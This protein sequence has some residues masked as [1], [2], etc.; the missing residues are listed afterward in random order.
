M[1][2]YRISS[3][4]VAVTT[5]AG[6]DVYDRG[7]HVAD[8]SSRTEVEAIAMNAGDDPGLWRAIPSDDDTL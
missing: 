4:F 3:R 6:Y 2:A 1:T 7:V 8:V 5:E